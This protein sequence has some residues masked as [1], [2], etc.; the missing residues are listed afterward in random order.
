MHSVSMYMYVYYYF[1]QL[2]HGRSHLVRGGAAK[3]C[4]PYSTYTMVNVILHD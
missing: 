1:S 4:Q 2:L 3:T